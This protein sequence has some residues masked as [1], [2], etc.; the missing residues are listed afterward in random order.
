MKP[1]QG[2]GFVRDTF[3]IDIDALRAGCK[4]DFQNFVQKISPQAIFNAKEILC[5]LCVLCVNEF[6]RRSLMQVPKKIRRDE[7]KSEHDLPD[8]RIN[9]NN[10]VNPLI[11]L[12]MFRQTAR[13]EAPVYFLPLPPPSFYSSVI[14]LSRHYSFPF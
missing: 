10:P 5:A 14:R 2:L 6:S 11:L 3:S 1:L 8:S 9:R 13:Q 4:K 12:I 7:E